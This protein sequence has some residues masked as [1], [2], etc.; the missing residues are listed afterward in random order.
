MHVR[1]L[2][3]AAISLVVLA[4]PAFSEDRGQVPAAQPPISQQ[5]GAAVPQPPAG[6]PA[7]A[8]VAAAE[9]A[10]E[11]R[12]LE[13]EFQKALDQN[14]QKIDDLQKQ[15]AAIEAGAAANEKTQI[16]LLRSRIDLLERFNQQRQ[17]S[18]RQLDQLRFE[19]GRS[20]ISF[21]IE[22]SG[23]LK[24]ATGLAASLSDF[25][26]SLN[27]SN[28][29]DFRDN[30]QKLI[31][32]IRDN[33]G[34]VLSAA[35]TGGFLAN[36][37]VSLAMSVV[38]V[39]MSNGAQSDKLG[40]LR[41]VV[42]VAEF[43]S[44]TT[45]DYRFVDNTVKALDE[46]VSAFNRAMRERFVTYASTVKYTH[47]W[48]EYRTDRMK[49]GSDPITTFAETF[50]KGLPQ[51]SAN[52]PVSAELKVV[53]Y[54]IANVRDYIAEYESLLQ[55]ISAFYDG[56]EAIVKKNSVATATPFCNANPSIIRVKTRLEGLQP[57][58]VKAKGDFV[59]AYMK[60][61]IPPESRRALFADQ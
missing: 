45:P 21:L 49:F 9:S 41:N 25:Q 51:P 11:L 14:R 20:V 53:R 13:V 48:D 44:E 31:P 40:H 38:S 6:A 8:P 23:S 16:D 36:P 33:N 19:T 17:N 56:F 26:V 58:V 50:F 22:K 59:D 4:S 28:D 12:S 35:Q 29:E 60:P 5:P 54:Q 43:T 10:A 61:T 1:M 32:R 47:S 46:R 39:F 57:K 27:P 37:Y 7:P 3:L 34:P 18:E 42:C 2:F 52:D 24:V 30:I 55:Q 15:I